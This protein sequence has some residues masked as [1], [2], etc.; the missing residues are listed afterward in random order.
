MTSHAIG[1]AAAATASEA[2]TSGER[3]SREAGDRSAQT[4]KATAQARIGV[5]RYRP[6]A[7][8]IRGARITP[9]KMTAASAEPHRTRRST[10]VP[11]AYVRRSPYKS[12]NTRARNK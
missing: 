12:D 6:Y 5:K 10:V 9:A 7:P 8:S 3:A 1:S 11:Q 4:T 2:S